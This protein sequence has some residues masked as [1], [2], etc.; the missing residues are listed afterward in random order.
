MSEPFRTVAEAFVSTTRR[1]PEQEAVVSADGRRYCYLEVREQVGRYVS[2]LQ[3]LGCAVDSKNK[4]LFCQVG[5]V[6]GDG[7]IIAR[8]ARDAGAGRTSTQADATQER[9]LTP[10][11]PRG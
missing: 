1:Y 7:E 9:C 10:S 4:R 2:V 3:A 11:R 8:G 6:S 5:P